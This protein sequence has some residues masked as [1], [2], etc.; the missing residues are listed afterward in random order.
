MLVYINGEFRGSKLVEGKNSTYNMVYGEDITGES[1][2]IYT[3][4]SKL[5]NFNKGDEGIF[6]CELS[7]G[8][9]FPKFELVGFELR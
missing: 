7:V 3:K 4:D 1:F 5:T 2:S 8:G 6:K 9:K